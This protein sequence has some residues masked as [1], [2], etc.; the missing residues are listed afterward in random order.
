MDAVTVQETVETCFLA[1][2]QTFFEE[3]YF[4]N[5]MMKNLL[6]SVLLDNLASINLKNKNAGISIYY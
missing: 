1:N 5:E 2:L 4:E 6:F 3:T